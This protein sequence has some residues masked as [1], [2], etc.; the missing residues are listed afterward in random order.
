M[1]DET[2][3]GDTAPDSGAFYWPPDDNNDD[4]L[5]DDANDA[6]AAE[7]I[8][9]DAGTSYWADAG[10]HSEMSIEDSGATYVEEAYDSGD[11][12][13][14]EDVV[15][16]AGETS[17]SPALA[18]AGDLSQNTDSG[19]AEAVADSGPTIPPVMDA[20]ASL[21]LLDGAV[22]QANDAGTQNA[23]TNP[24]SDFYLADGNPYSPTQG[25]Y[26]SPRDNIGK[27]SAYYFGSGG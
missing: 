13:P 27:V 25:D 20:G 14:W 24:M 4:P 19:A 11:D 18:D 12:D 5:E 22:A 21:D 9:T 8:P 6:G 17:E 3:A 26:F 1:S 15:A 16:D 7:T 2:D 10:N 23:A